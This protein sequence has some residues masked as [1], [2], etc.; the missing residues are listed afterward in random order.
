MSIYTAVEHVYG[1]KVVGS[2]Y[3]ALEGSRCFGTTVSEEYMVVYV[4]RGSDGTS[5]AV[6]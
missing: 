5:E 4:R 2:P 1:K 3:V 6:Y